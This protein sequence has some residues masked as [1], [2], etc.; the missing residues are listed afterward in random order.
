[1][2]TILRKVDICLQFFFGQTQSRRNVYSCLF[3]Q[4]KKSNVNSLLDLV[5]LTSLYP[6]LY[7]Q[8]KGKV[9]QC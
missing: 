9:Q 5:I 4:I 8:R 7:V 3:G 1:M 6:N 2:F